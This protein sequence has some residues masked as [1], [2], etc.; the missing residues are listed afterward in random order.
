MGETLAIMSALASVA[1]A[2]AG[3]VG[4]LQ[5][6]AAANVERQQIEESARLASLQAKQAEEER[7][8]ELTRTL[9]TQDAIRGGRGVDLFSPTG[10]TIRDQT[11]AD[12]EADIENIRINQGSAAARYGLAGQAASARGTGALVG[13][14]GAAAGGLLS[15]ARALQPLVKAS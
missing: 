5:G 12:A 13:G 15:G 14:I 2:G 9:A 3:L 10:N 8:K 11:F 4:G 7:R 6:R 1:S